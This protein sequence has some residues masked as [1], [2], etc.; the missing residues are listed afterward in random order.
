MHQLRAAGWAGGCWGGGAGYEKGGARGGVGIARVRGRLHL[1]TIV[2]ELDPIPS[3]PEG[4][5]RHRADAV[6][7]LIG[8]SGVQPNDAPDF[9]AINAT[10]TERCVA[11]ARAYGELRLR[12]GTRHWRQQCRLPRVRRRRLENCEW[13]MAGC[14]SQ[15]REGKR[16]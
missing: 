15:R 7:F 11:N 2:R 6:I 5:G 4:S 14:V 13:P 3:E 8:I 12:S 1:E 16:V 10:D 9:E